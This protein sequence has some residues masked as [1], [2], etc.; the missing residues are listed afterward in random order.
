VTSDG[1]GSQKS[2][3][4]RQ[5]ERVQAA[6]TIGLWLVIIIFAWLLFAF[7]IQAPGMVTWPL[8]VVD[9]L[10][11]DNPL[12][13]SRDVVA[14]ND[15]FAIATARH[16]VN[17]RGVNA[18]SDNQP[19]WYVN[20]RSGLERSKGAWLDDGRGQG[21][22][23]IVVF[24]HGYNTDPDTAV[25]YARNLMNLIG[26][27]NQALETGGVA[28]FPNSSVAGVAFLWR[29][30][31]SEARFI[32]ARSA[33]ETTVPAFED[34]IRSLRSDYP[35]ARI[36]IVA[37]SLGG[38]LTL[39]AMTRFDESAHTGVFADSLTLLQAAA[40][41]Y[42]LHEWNMSY[43]V[44]TDLDK[45]VQQ[46]RCIGRYVEHH[47]AVRQLIYTTSERDE[48]LTDAGRMFMPAGG[49]FGFAQ[50]MKPLN[51]TCGAPDQS[52][53]DRVSIGHPF[54][55]TAMWSFPPP[56]P[57][58]A[59]EPIPSTSPATSVPRP[60]APPVRLPSISTKY[61]GWT[62]DPSFIRIPL[63]AGADAHSAILQ[64]ADDVAR[65]TVKDIWT[66]VRI[67]FAEP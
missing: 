8:A 50:I 51:V 13:P 49:W 41:A 45:A 59:P 3:F 32:A 16:V 28:S 11:N 56:T 33:A 6:L 30:D 66:R 57:P 19:L 52:G 2:W 58:A 23:V 5:P 25:A 40:P 43:Y 65:K 54:D 63:P 14:E 31:L 48:A 21:P 46:T 44:G 38:Y 39:E 53:V 15:H 9:C 55:P 7:K 18:R 61:D 20:G 26:D 29:G 47:R 22:R 60:Y 36:V 35:S 42:S 67:G 1:W 37:H 4:D 17:C 34:F 64:D 12:T 27:A 10:R 24:V 62:I